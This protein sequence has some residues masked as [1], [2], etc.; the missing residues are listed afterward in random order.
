MKKK[1]IAAVV[2]A[3]AALFTAGGTLAWFTDDRTANSVIQTG[4]VDIEVLESTNEPEGTYEKTSDGIVYS[5]HFMPGQTFSKIVTVRNNGINSAYVRV[6]VSYQDHEKK[7]LR[8]EK[9]LEP[10]V[11]SSG[12]GSSGDSWELGSDGYYYYNQALKPGAV[13]AP[14]METVH[15]PLGWE[16]EQT[17]SLHRVVIMAEAIQSDFTGDTAKEAFGY[18]E[19]GPGIVSKSK[20]LAAE[21]QELSNAYREAVSQKNKEEQER[22]LKEIQELMEVDDSMNWNQINNNDKFRSALAKVNGDW[23]TV[24]EEG[25]AEELHMSEE[26]S[27]KWYVNI[28][29]VVKDNYRVVPY[30]SKAPRLGGGDQWKARYLQID[31]VW[32]QPVGAESASSDSVGYISELY[33][34]GWDGI[35][36]GWKPVDFNN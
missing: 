24:A 8:Y 28:Y 27:Q 36:D 23:P 5:G 6:K 15:L 29:V 10:V 16:L 19:V 12:F 25:L 33:K 14:V 26:E 13:T 34:D 22:I 35:K 31:G 3:V 32:Y 18:Q 11:E 30:I 1:L 20:K 2:V 17:T 4:N 7:V 21:F 9:K